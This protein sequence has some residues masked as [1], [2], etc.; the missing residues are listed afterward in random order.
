VPGAQGAAGSPGPQG[1]AG[2]SGAT[3]VSASTTSASNPAANTLVTAVANCPAGN[4]ALGGGAYVT[5][6]SPNKGRVQLVG[7]YPSAAGQWTAVAAVN[8]TLGGNT[9]TITAYVLC[10]L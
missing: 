10:S 9:L 5:T 8:A 3:L 7:S 6:T 2:P 4:V 1:P